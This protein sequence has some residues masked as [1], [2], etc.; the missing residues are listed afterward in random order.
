MITYPANE[1]TIS[2][3][4]RGLS[5]QAIVPLAQG[6][7]LVAGETILFAHS[8]AR[9]G[10]PPAYVKGGDSVLVL[11]TG[12]TD[13]GATDPDTG[14][15]LVQVRWERLGQEAPSTSASKRIPRSTGSQGRA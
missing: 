6:L 8:R 5:C 10:Q 4:E 11:V 9:P 7:S 2:Q 3:V 15:M 14:Q 1:Q 12:V 13:L